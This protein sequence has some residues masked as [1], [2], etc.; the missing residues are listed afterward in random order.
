MTSHELSKNQRGFTLIEVLM[1]LM[2]IGI[3]TYVSLEA[4][5]SS[6]ND[7]KFQ[8]TNDEMHM[9][10][11]AI[12]GS[13]KLNESGSRTSF[14][15]YGDVGAL[16]PTIG[17]LTT[18]PGTVSVYTVNSTAR[19]AVGWNGPYLEQG[20]TSVDYTTDG[21]GTAYVYDNVAGTLTSYGADKVAGGTG[22]NQDIV[23]SFPTNERQATVQGFVS[24]AGAPPTTA[25]YGQVELNYPN[26]TGGLTQSLQ[27]VG[28]GTGGSFSF[29]NVPYGI[30]S[31]TV[32]KPDKATA[33]SP[34]I[35]GPFVITVDKPKTLVPSSIL[36]F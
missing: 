2:L 10:A 26:G 8:E 35:L 5:N 36:D 12:V 6:T 1:V 23:I 29:S 33:V 25:S 32:Y 15:Y 28:S 21:W 7:A 18:M 34:N 17:G 4:I 16:P 22:L 31:I 20:D 27:Y 24:V 19:T 11:D 14:G 9:I 13:R 3:L 30:R